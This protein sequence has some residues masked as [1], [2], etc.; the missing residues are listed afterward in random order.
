MKKNWYYA[1]AKLG[2]G[3]EKND[4]PAVHWHQ[5]QRIRYVVM[6]DASPDFAEADLEAVH[7]LPPLHGLGGPAGGRV[8]QDRRGLRLT[9]ADAGA[10]YCRHK[11]LLRLPVRY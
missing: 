3:F 11:R 4:T 2:S 6:K 10:D 9:E 1:E 7:S 8:G 5:R